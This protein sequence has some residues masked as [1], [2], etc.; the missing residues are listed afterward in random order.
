[1]EYHLINIAVGN[2]LEILK[3]SVQIFISIMKKDD[4]NWQL[5]IK[6]INSWVNECIDNSEMVQILINSELYFGDDDL[7]RINTYYYDHDSEIANFFDKYGTYIL[8]NN[9]IS[10]EYD[11]RMLGNFFQGTEL[12][13]INLDDGFLNI[14]IFNQMEE[15]ERY[16]IKEYDEGYDQTGMYYLN[17]RIYDIDIESD[18]VMTSR[19]NKYYGDIIGYILKEEG[20]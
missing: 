4:P 5:H 1:M 3:R 8:F 9:L 12:D 18:E 11:D 17:G 10:M 14:T 20:Y 16:N 7:I 6:E 2:F 19:I 15:P 13:N